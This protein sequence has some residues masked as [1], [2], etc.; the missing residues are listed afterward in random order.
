L[1]SIRFRVRAYLEAA[2]LLSPGLSRLYYSALALREYLSYRPTPDFFFGEELFDKSKLVV[3]IDR[4]AP[5]PNKDSGSVRAIQIINLLITLGYKV[6][7]CSLDGSRIAD[8]HILENP[9]GISQVS[10]R[11]LHSLLSENQIPIQDL[12]IWVSRF[13]VFR[14][15]VP[16]MRWTKGARIIFDTVDLH[17]LRLTRLGT[18]LGDSLL[19][20]LGEKVLQQEV[21]IA[22]LAQEVV[23]VSTFEKD[24]L[25]GCEIRSVLVTNI[26][27]LEPNNL[28]WGDRV[29]QVFIGNFN[30][31]P[32]QIS[33]MWYLNHVWPILPES[34]RLEGLKV[35]GSP[36]PMIGR[37]FLDS[38]IELLGWV[39]DPAHEIQRAKVS[40]APIVAGAGVKGKIGQAMAMGTPVITTPLGAEGMGLQ[41]GVELEVADSAQGFADFVQAL[42]LDGERNA[43]L[44][45]AARQAIQQKYSR[46]AALEKLKTLVQ[47]E[48]D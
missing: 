31:L 12:T 48:T 20:R 15:V 30:H 24:F 2:F 14:A 3:M 41:P 22:K 19:A 39:Q 4:S 46:A 7:F 29:G 8:S 32:N 42:M 13:P 36:K 25:N 34:V 33:L 18:S 28:P 16:N 6:I 35:I 37:H 40:I 23:V 5:D 10:K 21:L 45:K 26:H 43:R 1:G 44:A 9:A 27:D 11:R 47:G 17:G 38:N